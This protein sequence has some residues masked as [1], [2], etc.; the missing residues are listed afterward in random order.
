MYSRTLTKNSG[1]TIIEILVIIIIVLIL[2]A[3]V[4]PKF[5]D[6]ERKNRQSNVQ[7]NMQ[8]VDMAVKKYATSNKGNY[9]LRCDDPALKSFFPGGNTN[10]QAPLGGN[11]PENPFTHMPEAPFPGNVT[12]VEQTRQSSPADLGGPRMA[13]KIFYNALIPA[14]KEKAIGYAIQGAGRDG[15]AIAGQTPNTTSVLSNL[16]TQPAKSQAH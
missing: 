7:E 2:A 11:Y 16:I 12:D 5:F 10:A 13:G 8:I 14:E 4:L 9:P 6:M 15:R 3:V 1:F